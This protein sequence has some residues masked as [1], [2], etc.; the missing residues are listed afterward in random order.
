M[1]HREGFVEQK[2]EKTYDNYS[3]LYANTT[4]ES[5]DAEYLDTER[6]YIDEQKAIF[7][8]EFEKEIYIPSSN[9]LPINPKSNEEKMKNAIKN[10]EVVVKD[11]KE[12]EGNTNTVL[13][14]NKFADTI[15]AELNTI[16]FPVGGIAGPAFKD[17]ISR[18][19]T[20]KNKYEGQMRYLLQTDTDIIDVKIQEIDNKIQTIKEKFKQKRK[21]N[22]A[23]AEEK[24][25]SNEKEKNRKEAEEK[26]IKE[27]E[28][29]VKKKDERR[30]NLEN[31]SGAVFDI[32]LDL[33][34][35]MAK[36]KGSLNDNGL[37]KIKESFDILI[38][39]Y[40]T[41]LNKLNGVY[42]NT[43]EIIDPI[44]NKKNNII[45]LI[46]AQQRRLDLAEKTRLDEE[47][48]KVEAKRLENEQKAKAEAKRLENEQKAKA[49]T[50]RLENEAEAKRV[51][52][53]AEAKRL[54]NEAE[55]SKKYPLRNMKNFLLNYKQSR[56][57]KSLIKTKNA[58]TNRE[59]LM[60]LPKNANTPKVIIDKYKQYFNIY[61][62]VKA[63]ETEAIR[64]HK[65]RQQ[66]KIPPKAFS[67]KTYAQSLKGLNQRGITPTLRRNSIK[68]GKKRYTRTIKRKQK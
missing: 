3:K 36:L 4:I 33:D 16:V 65:E 35:L 46:D 68:G 53:N 6:K 37:K 62:D 48:R 31:F 38:S 20:I 40:E 44:V 19:N 54:A 60:K 9:T 2:L 61:K 25:L 57:D 52:N 63:R 1:Q 30:K 24:R 45:K 13:N 32:T 41:E 28:E 43:K 8:K 49:E 59:N 21:A 22:E 34:Q 29:I 56:Y 23:K 18:F 12:I 27:A 55:Y 42:T 47:E 66:S 17:L 39:K 10:A 7:K 26:A 67:G 15:K 5:E 11:A 50:K 51:A 58:S 14:A 64:I